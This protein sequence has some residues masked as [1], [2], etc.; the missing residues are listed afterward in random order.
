MTNRHWCM[1]LRWHKFLELYNSYDNVHVVL[2]NQWLKLITVAVRVNTSALQILL[3][4]MIF[5]SR[6]GKLF[7]FFQNQF[8]NLAFVIGAF[9]YLL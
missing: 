5:E 6:N 2:Q 4:I 1:E 7:F 8:F 9:L 3:Q